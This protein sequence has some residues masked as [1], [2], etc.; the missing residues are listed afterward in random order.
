MEKSELENRESRIQYVKQYRLY[1][2]CARQ[3][4][5]PFDSPPFPLGGSLRVTRMELL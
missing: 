3:G 2:T 1:P 5:D 4:K